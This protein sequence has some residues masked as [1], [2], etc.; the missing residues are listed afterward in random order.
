[1]SQS[2]ETAPRSPQSRN[3]ETNKKNEKNQL[4]P[5]SFRSREIANE[6]SDNFADV[7]SSDTGAY[8]GLMLKE[9]GTEAAR[10]TYREMIESIPMPAH[11]DILA[12]ALYI[13]HK[14]AQERDPDYKLSAAVIQAPQT[15]TGELAFAWAANTS[16]D[17][18]G[19]AIVSS[20]A[21]NAVR[22][23][24]KGRHFGTGLL[25]EGRQLV[26][27][28]NEALNSLQLSGRLTIE[29]V[30]D[31]GASDDYFGNVAVVMSADS[32]GKPE[33]NPH[34]AERITKKRVRQEAAVK[35]AAP[36]PT[37]V[38]SPV[39]VT[40]SSCSIPSV[41]TRQPFEAPRPEE[42]VAEP[43]Q[44]EMSDEELRAIEDE[45]RGFTVV[46]KRKRSRDELLDTPLDALNASIRRDAPKPPQPDRSPIAQ[47]YIIPP[48][49]DRDP[50]IH[51]YTI[52]P[53]PDHEPTIHLVAASAP[54]TEVIPAVSSEDSSSIELKSDWKDNLRHPFTYLASRL[55][56]ANFMRKNNREAQGKSREYFG[57]DADKQEKAAKIALG[58][59]AVALVSSVAA[60]KLG[61]EMH[62]AVDPSSAI[63]FGGTYEVDR[64]P[65]AKAAEE[66]ARQA[67]IATQHAEVLNS[68]ANS[69]PFGGGG[70]TYATAN[71]A[72]IDVWY[73]NQN[74]FLQKFPAE[75][76]VMA[77][78]NVGMRPGELSD[79]AKEF[80]AKKF[81]KWL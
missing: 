68:P 20:D 1:M 10:Q 41:P 67:A 74:E 69:I 39:T 47:N 33:I 40:T 52:P 19:I 4:S 23:G 24:A 15:N 51:N 72:D 50:I 29:G 42:V 8:A 45:R 61:W 75:G 35:A 62:D 21:E 25:K 78:G 64:M 30:Q 55:S 26:I 28:D 46:N 57:L 71:G 53:K 56:A 44:N 16:H 5:V 14:E 54:A 31:I 18:T 2:L 7:I 3:S 13:S 60:W 59:V 11:K 80:W 37:V 66:A 63:P 48:K 73:Q 36:Q 43:S 9:N 79:G 77:D 17:T 12:D 65:G 70:E 32:A 81:G 58:A 76:Y 34:L 27:A 22:L 38:A 49:P 6:G